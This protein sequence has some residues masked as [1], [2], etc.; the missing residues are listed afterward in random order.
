MINDFLT[1][2]CKVIPTSKDSFG[3]YVKSTPTLIKCR[4]KEKHQM[5]KNKAAKEVVSQIEFWF[6]SEID[7]QLDYLIEFNKK[8][9][10]IISMRAKK[11]SLGNIT[12]KVVFV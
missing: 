11:D 3:K 7:I 10:P 5:V 4:A 9:Y 1:E 6:S 12:R 8:E 2:E